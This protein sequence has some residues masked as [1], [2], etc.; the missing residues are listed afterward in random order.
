MKIP[1]SSDTYIQKSTKWL[2][3]LL[4]Y[5]MIVLTA[6]QVGLATD[7]LKGNKT[8]QRLSLESTVFSIWAPLIGIF[9]LL[10]LT[11]FQSLDLEY[12]I[13]QRRPSND[14]QYRL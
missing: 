11:L 8:F 4:I 10:G 7:R 13:L 9:V 2:V 1:Y 12:G 5:V 6:M 14:D 3:G